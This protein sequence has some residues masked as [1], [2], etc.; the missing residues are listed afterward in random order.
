LGWCTIQSP[1]T[2]RIGLRLVD[3]GNII[4]ANTT[5]LVVINQFQPISVYFTL[6]ENELPAVLR[7]L[8]ADRKVPVDAYD[9]ADLEKLASGQLLTADNQI[10]TTTGTD[11]LKAV[12]ANSDNLLFPDQFVNI[13]LVMESRARA[14]VVPSA[15]IQSGV[16]GSYVWATDTDA[17]GSGTVKMQPVKVALT[18]GQITI[19]DGGLE[20]GDRVV[21]DGA[22][23]L[24]PGARVIASDAPPASNTAP[25]SADLGA[26]KRETHESAGGGA[27]GSQ[28]GSQGTVQ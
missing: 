6:P 14:L 19:L 18:Q 27:S 2:G 11:K 22:D 8:A 15:A 16:Q 21:V 20:R 5:N 7:K 3:P 10:D 1:I 4:T 24:R 12:F 17:T 13:H 9:H 23:R 25:V 28:A 26:P